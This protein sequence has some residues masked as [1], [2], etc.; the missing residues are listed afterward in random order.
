MASVGLTKTVCRPRPRSRPRPYSR[1]ALWFFMHGDI[2]KL[3]GASQVFCDFV[4]LL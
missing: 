2:S 3:H 1:T 4:V